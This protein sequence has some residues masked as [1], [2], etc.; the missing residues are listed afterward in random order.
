MA[1]VCPISNRKKGYPFEV[2]IPGL[3]VTGVVLSDQMKNLDFRAGATGVLTRLD[4]EIVLQVV[5]KVLPL[6]DPDEVFGG[7]DPA[8]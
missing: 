8:R 1:L 3:P 7:S 5:E 4:E 2:E 6:L